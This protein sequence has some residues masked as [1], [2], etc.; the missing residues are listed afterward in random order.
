MNPHPIAGV[1]LV[2]VTLLLMIGMNASHAVAVGN[3]L[4]GRFTIATTWFV[5]VDVVAVVFA[6]LV[7][8][9]GVR[10]KSA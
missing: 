1:V 8:I 9:L 4:S 7:V 3:S 5:L 2:V 6:L 10:R